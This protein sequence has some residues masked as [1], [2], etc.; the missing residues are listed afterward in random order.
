M[1][2]VITMSEVLKPHWARVVA[3]G[4]NLLL[5]ND[6]WLTVVSYVVMY[7]MRCCKNMDN[8]E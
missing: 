4:L 5:N 3:C 1:S 6:P 8:I 7:Y 2:V